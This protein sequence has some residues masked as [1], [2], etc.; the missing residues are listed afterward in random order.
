MEEIV[1]LLLK[2]AEQL[3]LPA[4]LQIQLPIC[5]SLIDA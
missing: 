2:D 3:L 4:K 5:A 1:Q